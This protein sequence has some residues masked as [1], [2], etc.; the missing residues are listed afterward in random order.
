[1]AVA[2]ELR[3]STGEVIARAGPLGCIADSAPSDR[4]LPAGLRPP[5]G[6]PYA[7]LSAARLRSPFARFAAAVALLRTAYLSFHVLTDPR[8]IAREVS[9][10]ELRRGGCFSIGERGIQ[11]SRHGARITNLQ[12]DETRF[13]LSN[14]HGFGLS[15]GSDMLPL[16]AGGAGIDV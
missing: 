10:A 2:H 14:E 3:D 4:P 13:E 16:G 11:G 8:G 5:P 7:P 9:R 12:H 1:M 6:R 15:D